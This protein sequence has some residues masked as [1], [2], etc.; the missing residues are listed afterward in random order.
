LT[1]PSGVQIG[2]TPSANYYNNPKSG[3]N[4]D[5]ESITQLSADLLSNFTLSSLSVTAND[6]VLSSGSNLNLAAGGSLTV[7]A[8]PIDM[9]GNGSAAGGSA[10]LGTDR[11]SLSA[12]FPP[13]FFKKPT[14][15]PGKAGNVIAANVYIEGTIDVSGRFVNDIGRTAADMSGPAY[16]DGG[17]I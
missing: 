2:A 6:F 12:A 3:D 5:G 7:S 11:V 16:I 10:N 15:K 4:P 14:D 1:T 8:A 17:S 9:A 13:S